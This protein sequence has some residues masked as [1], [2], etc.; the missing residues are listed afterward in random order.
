MPYDLRREYFA[1]TAHCAPRASS[2][3]R[4]HPMQPKSPTRNT[5]VPL[6]QFV[7]L[8]SPSKCLK[9][10]FLSATWS[11]KH[12]RFYCLQEHRNAL[13][14]SNIG[15]TDG[16]VKPLIVLFFSYFA[17]LAANRPAEIPRTVVMRLAVKPFM[18]WFF[19]P[20]YHLQNLCGTERNDHMN[21]SPLITRCE[22]WVHLAKPII[23]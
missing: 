3:H 4:R 20:S 11:S 9:P 7:S 18:T 10:I 22:D 19:F 14:A 8:L 15:W 13:H 1:A 6:K 21:S 12:Q 23:E 5:L 2:F 17:Q 16:C